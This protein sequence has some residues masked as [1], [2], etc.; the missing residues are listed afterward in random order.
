MGTGLRH[1]NTFGGATGQIYVPPQSGAFSVI[2]SIYNRGPLEVTIEAVSIL[3]PQ[4][5]ADAGR[6]TAPWP[7]RPAGPV[8]WAFQYTRPG[9]P[10]LPSGRFV[11]GLVLPPGQGMALGIPLQMNGVCYD[12]GGWTHTDVFYV[13]ERFL[14][15]THWVAVS[16]QPGLILHTPSPPGGPAAE[17]ASELVCPAG[18]SKGVTR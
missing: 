6:D 10:D 1:V 17:P 5:R 12:P 16:F 9:Q 8:R 18:T 3:S 13:K 11:A 7:L 14:F 15:F 2:P 4:Q